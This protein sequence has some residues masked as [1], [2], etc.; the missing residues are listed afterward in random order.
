MTST[1]PLRTINEL[2]ARYSLEPE[3]NDVFVEGDFDNRILSRAYETSDYKIYS[4][5]TVSIE[6]ELLNKH[7]FTIGNKQKVIVVARELFAELSSEHSTL[8]IVDRDLD[9]WF[10][11]LEETFGLIWTKYCSIELYF[12]S[13]N[14]IKNIL[15][16]SAR[17]NIN[18]FK[19]FYKSL[20]ATLSYLYA[21]RL[22]DKELK[23][24]MAWLDTLGRFLSQDGSCIK[25]DSINYSV[26]LLNK[27]KKRSL[28]KKFETTVKKHLSNLTGDPRLY[29]RGHDF[30]EILAWSI[31]QFSN[32]KKL[33]IRE[34]IE[35]VM[36]LLSDRV[37]D[38]NDLLNETSSIKAQL[39]PGNKK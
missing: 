30:I 5:D 17:C 19:K 15:I 14:L 38:M 25:F 33:G 21:M 9:H 13:E 32:N 39:L 18:D 10:E 23:W 12:F 28:E 16:D 29:I 27:N 36:V 37:E 8:C 7:S 26:G 22:A 35:G 1:L 6:K 4:I 3:I 34:H 2:I 20:V 24:S 11:N 31:R